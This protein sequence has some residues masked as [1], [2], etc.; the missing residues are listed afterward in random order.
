M[1]SSYQLRYNDSTRGKNGKPESA[2]MEIRWTTLTAGNLVGEQAKLATLLAA[3]Q[4]VSLGLLANERIVLSDTYSGA[5]FATDKNAQRETKW[6]ISMEDNVTHRLESFT[7]P[8]ADLTLLPDNH[9]EFLDLTSGAG[10][11][12]KNAIEAGYRSINDNA[13][14]VVSI[15]HVGRNL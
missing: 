14:T 13:C 7:I 8:C 15:K 12:L 6:L 11:T 10:Q 9:E 5:G 4:A 3:V 2:T 1:A